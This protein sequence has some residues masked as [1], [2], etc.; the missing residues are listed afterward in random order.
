MR[1]VIFVCTGNTCRS[2]MAAGLFGAYAAEKGV[3]SLVTV[4]SAGLAALENAPVSENAVRAAA[5]L[6]ADIAQHRAHNLTADMVTAKTRFVC[7]TAQ[8]ALA[9]QNAGI[10]KTQ[11]LALDVSDPYGGDE[12]VYRACAQQLSAAMPLVFRFVFGC[13]DIR[14]MQRQDAEAAAEIE[15]ACFAHPWSEAALLA[16]LEQE[17]ARFFLLTAEGRPAGYIGANLVCGEGYMNNLAVLSAFRRRGFGR[18]LLAALTARLQAESAE[19]LTLEVRQSNAAAIALYREAGFK[20]AGIR[21]NFYRDPQ[22]DAV[23]L[24]LELLM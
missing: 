5:S 7:M 21:K 2:P 13:D 12:A 14:P 10:P 17:G 22:E 8:H 9:L 6:G 1:R 20:Q 24:T 11:L 16:S 19:F 3:A 15:R 18:M 23:L 4:C